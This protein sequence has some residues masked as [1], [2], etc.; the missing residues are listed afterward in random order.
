MPGTI[1]R[2]SAALQG[3]AFTTRADGCETAV[4]FSEGPFGDVDAAYYIRP[5]WDPLFTSLGGIALAGNDEAAAKDVV[6]SGGGWNTGTPTWAQL[7]AGAAYVAHD[8]QTYTGAAA[9]SKRMGDWLV[10]NTTHDCEAA[11]DAAY[12]QGLILAKVQA[13]ADLVFGA[14]IPPPAPVPVTPQSK[15]PPQVVG[16]IPSALTLLLAQGTRLT[17]GLDPGNPNRVLVG[18]IAVPT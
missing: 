10:A 15:Y 11:T 13:Q 1:S 4:N 14:Y 8:G 5:Q 17:S 9:V 3:A 16:T 12:F 18:A 6:T 2:L 7:E